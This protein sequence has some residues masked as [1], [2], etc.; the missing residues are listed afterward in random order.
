M[1][2]GKSRVLGLSGTIGKL[3]RALAGVSDLAQLTPRKA[4][5][6]YD[7]LST[8]PSARPLAAG[9]PSRRS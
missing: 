3:T 4:A 5:T 9:A 1:R 6:L 7:R 8:R 2:R